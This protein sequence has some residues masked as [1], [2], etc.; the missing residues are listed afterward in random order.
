MKITVHFLFLIG[1]SVGRYEN[2]NASNSNVYVPIG[3]VNNARAL[4]DDRRRA[5]V[6]FCVFLDVDKHFKVFVQE[7]GVKSIYTN[8]FRLAFVV[9]FF[10]AR[11]FIMFLPTNRMYCTF[12]L[13]GFLSGEPFHL[14]NFP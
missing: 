6:P 4:G 10:F 12:S 8:F 1:A 9:C 2:Y 3:L 7:D 11:V 13:S 14:K 5:L